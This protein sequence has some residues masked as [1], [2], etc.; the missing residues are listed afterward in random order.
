M[1][2]LEEYLEEVQERGVDF[3]D[4]VLVWLPRL[5]ETVKYIEESKG[6]IKALREVNARSQKKIIDMRT[7]INKL[8]NKEGKK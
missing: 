6:E 7:E 4:L 3:E 1:N 5:K 8:K 2:I